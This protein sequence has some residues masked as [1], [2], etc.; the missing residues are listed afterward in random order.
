MVKQINQEEFE[1]QVLS[2]EGYVF[3]D[4]FATWCGPCKM[5]SPIMEDISSAHKVYK[6]DVDEQEEL[7]E[8]F[9]VMSIPCVVVFKGG[10]EIAR[11]V[12]LKP[13]DQILS[14]IEE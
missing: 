8:K 5:L 1:Q 14:M 12:G 11:S 6:I 13:K 4:F 2:D 7:A 10:K 3:V 9:G